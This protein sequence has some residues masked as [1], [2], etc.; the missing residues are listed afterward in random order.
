MK[1]GMNLFLWTSD[2]DDALLPTLERLKGMGFDAVE[3]PVF[4]E[5]QARF[6]RLGRQ[7]D[8]LGL[9]RTAA[10]ALM[11]EHDPISP[12]PAVRRGATDLL[13]RRIDCAAAVGASLIVGPLHSALGSFSGKPPTS[14]E[15]ARSVEVLRAV[16]PQAA[17]LGV[18]LSIEFLNRF[19]CYLLNCAADTVRYVADVGHP[20]CGMLFDTFHAHIEEKDSA[21]AFAAHAGAV[22]HVHIAENDR[23]TP[24]AGQVA[25]D[26]IFPAIR[27]SGY[28]GYLTVEAF[29]MS[30]P[31][32]AAATKIWRR[33][34]ESEEALASGALAFMR[35]SWAAALAVS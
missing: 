28:D 13:R 18:G 14:G 33:M 21:R 34:F 35:R 25:W 31:A 9:A 5:D 24:G 23:G 22:N 17:D 29:G 7:L 1:F 27:A 2:V 6:A 11:A 26:R 10:T 19:E 32:L 20:A 15:W 3:V 30:L 16:C 8:D 4:H 12:D